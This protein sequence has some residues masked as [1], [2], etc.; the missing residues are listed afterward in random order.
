M[1][2]QSLSA[3]PVPDVSGFSAVPSWASMATFVGIEG[4][5]QNNITVCACRKSDSWRCAVD[6]GLSFLSCHCACHR[7]E[8]RVAGLVPLQL[9][10]ITGCNA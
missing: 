7:V 4:T 2:S 1:L 5:A 3:S 9:I 6:L 8:N 10:P